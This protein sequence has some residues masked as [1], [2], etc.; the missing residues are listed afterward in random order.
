LHVEVQKSRIHGHGVVATSSIDKGEWQHVYGQVVSEWNPYVFE[1][2]P[3]Y[4]PYAPFRFLN[5]SDEPNCEVIEE[6][7]EL[8]LVAIQNVS[9]GDELTIDYGEHPDEA[10]TANSEAG[11]SVHHMDD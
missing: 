2:E 7:G 10:A 1:G 5:H 6:D 9:G 3:Y 4:Q 11:K 8:Y